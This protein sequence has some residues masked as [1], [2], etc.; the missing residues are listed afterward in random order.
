MEVKDLGGIDKQYRAVVP[1]F[2]CLHAAACTTVRVL[3][4]HSR[5]QS[6]HTPAFYHSVIHHQKDTGQLHW[7]AVSFTES[8]M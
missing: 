1:R 5:H 8:K 7:V 4:T 3:R 2:M 6:E